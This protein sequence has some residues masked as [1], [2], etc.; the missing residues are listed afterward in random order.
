MLTACH[1]STAPHS[2]CKDVKDACVKAL[3]AAF[4]KRRTNI[5]QVSANPTPNRSN[6]QELHP[7]NTRSNHRLH[8]LNR[9]YHRDAEALYE[10]TV[11]NTHNNGFHRGTNL[12]RMSVGQSVPSHVC[13][14]VCTSAAAPFVQN[15]ANLCNVCLPQARDRPKNYAQQGDSRQAL[16]TSRRAACQALVWTA[17]SCPGHGPHRTR[18]PTSWR[19]PRRSP[20]QTRSWMA[21]ST[22]QTQLGDVVPGPLLHCSSEVQAEAAFPP[23]ETI[24]G[25]L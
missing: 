9:L 18:S 10:M 14:S 25:R 17:H 16:Q 11:Q 7:P 8:C 6:V 15:V 4:D 2:V 5:D 23:L 21:P 3:P 22:W 1:H 12:S 24:S 19:D 20:S 13:K